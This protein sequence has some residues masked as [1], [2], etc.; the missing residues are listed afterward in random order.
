MSNKLYDYLKWIA[1]IALPA[2]AT[3]VAAVFPAYGVENT[4]TI[5]LTITSLSTLLG[6]LLGVSNVKYNKVSDEIIDLEIEDEQ[7]D[8]ELGA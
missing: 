3:Y 1:M 8:K 5:V 4:E 7:L 6:A 2:L